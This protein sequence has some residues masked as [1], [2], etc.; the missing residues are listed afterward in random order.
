MPAEQRSI[1]TLGTDDD[2]L[3]RE[4]GEIVEPKTERSN[5]RVTPKRSVA[6]GLC[7]TAPER[8]VVGAEEGKKAISQRRED[9]PARFADLGRSDLDPGHGELPALL[10]VDVVGMADFDRGEDDL[11]RT[12]QTDIDDVTASEPHFARHTPHLLRERLFDPNVAPFEGTFANDARGNAS[13]L[14]AAVDPARDRVDDE[15]FRGEVLDGFTAAGRARTMMKV[16]PLLVPRVQVDAV[17][18]RR[19]KVG[20]ALPCLRR[21]D[22]GPVDTPGEGNAEAA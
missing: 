19:A 6:L 20:D 12:K 16:A 1:V 14:S 8:P 5:D 15:Y 7:V 18:A 10:G 22:E 17:A 3:E 21:V 9:A 2:S 13:R 4:P 11:A